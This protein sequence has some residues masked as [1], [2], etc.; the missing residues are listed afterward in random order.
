MATRARAGR[1]G[2]ADR[3]RMPMLAGWLFVDLLLVLFLAALGGL[4]AGDTGAEPAV[5][6][7]PAPSAEPTP[8]A[9]PRVVER[10]PYT[11]TV[12]VSPLALRSGADTPAARRL[13]SGV[14]REL[15]RLAKAKPELERREVGFVLALG[16]GPD[17]DKGPSI[18]GAHEAIR[19]LQSRHPMFKN[20]A[21]IGRGYWTEGPA[22][23][24]EFVVLFYSD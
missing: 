13:L 7:P 9:G 14:T 19:T 16:A 4:P 20:A 6:P 15:A 1:A 21:D 10:K 11:F 22:T 17:S 2:R 23:S 8:K 12:R 24:V 18:A 3:M 5:A